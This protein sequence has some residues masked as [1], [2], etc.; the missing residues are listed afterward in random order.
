MF[1]NK[2]TIGREEL[3]M[4]IEMTDLTLYDKEKITY[5]F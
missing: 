2:R 4:K 1:F 5:R 3:P